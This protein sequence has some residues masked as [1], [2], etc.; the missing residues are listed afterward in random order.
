VKAG[1]KKLAVLVYTE[2]MMDDAR[3]QFGIESPVGWWTVSTTESRICSLDYIEGE[4]PASL[5][6]IPETRL[7]KRVHCLLT[8]YFRGEPVD[9]SRLPV[10]IP[11]QP[12][13]RARVMQ[14]LRNIP[15]GTVQSYQWVAEQLGNANAARAVGGALGRNPVPII[16]PCH[17]IV[18]KHGRL[19]GFMQDHADGARIKRFLLELEGHAFSDERRLSRR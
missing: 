15:A 18:A 12:A 13:L 5:R 7:E 16:V 2:A 8:R 19:G 3:Y 14:V 11:E 9:F 10:E 6:I 4:R 1:S 17:R